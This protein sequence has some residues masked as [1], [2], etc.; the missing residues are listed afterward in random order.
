MFA[1]TLTPTQVYWITRLDYIIV[2]SLS[3]TIL[4][5]IA[6]VLTGVNACE[7]SAMR[8]YRSYYKS[9]FWCF[10]FAVLCLASGLL[11]VFLPNTGDMME[12]IQASESVAREVK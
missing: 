8:E 2:A 1:L 7:K 11:P 3:I 5:G 4:V 12:I 9:L 10:V 6:S